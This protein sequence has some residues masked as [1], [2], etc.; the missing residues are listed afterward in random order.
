[1]QK[2][3]QAL[4]ISLYVGAFLFSWTATA[5][6]LCSKAHQESNPIRTPDRNGLILKVPAKILSEP[7]QWRHSTPIRPVLK[8]QGFLKTFEDSN[9]VY[10]LAGKK[11]IQVETYLIE[12]ERW[13]D[14]AELAL[15]GSRHR[16]LKKMRFESEHVFIDVIDTEIRA[17]LPPQ[18]FQ[19]AKVLGIDI[20]GL[21][22][23]D[24]ADLINNKDLKIRERLTSAHLLALKEGRDQHLKALREVLDFTFPLYRERRGWNE[25]F[26]K[27]L[28]EKAAETLNST[29]YIIVRRKLE[30]GKTGP[31]IANMGLTRAPYGA[32]DFF[33]KSTGQWERHFG[34]FGSAYNLSF[35]PEAD[36][37]T[38]DFTSPAFW[39]QGVPVVPTEVIF[40]TNSLSRPLVTDWPFLVD[41][42]MALRMK[43]DWESHGLPTHMPGIDPDFN[44][45]ISFFTGQIIEPVKFGIAKESDLRGVAYVE[46]LREMFAAIF[47]GDLSPKLTR[48]GQVLMTYNDRDGVIMYR[49]MGFSVPD[50]V[51]KKS[52]DGIEWSPLL[53]TPEKLISEI[54]QKQGLTESQAKS[55]F[56]SLI[57]NFNPKTGFTK[58]E[59]RNP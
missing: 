27:D 38:R 13:L 45:P 1:M 7:V 57:W 34:P 9:E 31:I 17:G 23:Q 36:A 58:K 25:N 24:L 53:M 5:K 49:R 47:P 44:Q 22:S 41:A 26:I 48:D 8:G 54:I 32:V 3:V 37:N 6:I 4:I 46:V 39:D 30:N 59:N 35:F 19:K 16:V 11:A 18:I 21:L 33:N 10:S 28:D 52:V 55:F 15:P 40:G 43:K 51:P 42:E 20:E 2:S 12:S 56:D 50:N 14:P 29:R